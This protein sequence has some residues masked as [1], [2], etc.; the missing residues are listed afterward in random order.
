MSN[1]SNHGDNLD[2]TLVDKNC[3][4]TQQSLQ[5]QTAPQSSVHLTSAHDHHYVISPERQI[6]PCIT[7]P[8]TMQSTP[9]QMMPQSNMTDFDLQRI[10]HTLRI[11]LRYEIRG[12]VQ[13]CVAE[14]VTPL[15]NELSVLKQSVTILTNKKL[16]WNKT[17]TMPINIAGV[18][19]LLLAMCQK[20]QM[21]PP[22]ISS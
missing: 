6:P 4:N 5:T 21:N 12:L 19:A 9:I 22:M 18:T 14:H 3:A 20:I 7:S 15:V 1:S 16:I 13:A 8:L 2:S 17:W 11:S 10:V